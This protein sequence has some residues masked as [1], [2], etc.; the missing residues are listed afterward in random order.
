MGD[1]THSRLDHTVIKPKQGLFSVNLLLPR[2]HDD[3]WVRDGV[4]YGL[5]REDLAAVDVQLVLHDHVLAQHG[6]VLHAD[7]QLFT[8]WTVFYIWRFVSTLHVA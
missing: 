2:S 3:L 8:K 7:L 1:E 5:V 6:H 4:A